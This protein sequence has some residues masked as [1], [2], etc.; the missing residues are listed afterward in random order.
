M[1]YTVLGSAGQIGKH[2][3]HFLQ[4][5]GHEVVEFDIL[6]A[7]YQ[8]LRIDYAVDS[9]IE[10]SDFTFFLAFDVGGSQYL[11]KYQNTFEFVDNNV[12]ILTNTFRALQATGKP[13]LFASTQMSNMNFSSYGTLKAVGE[14]YCRSLNSPIIKFW[15][16]YGV[17]T[18]PQKTHVITDFVKMALSGKPITM[19]TD[20]SEE[21]Q[22]L[23][24]SDCCEALY[25]LSLDYNRLSRL[26]EYHITSFEW[27]SVKHVASIISELCGGATIIPSIEH[28]TVQ[29]DQRNE[30][31]TFIKS[32]G[33]WE[34][35]MNLKNGI[36]RIVEYEKLH[37]SH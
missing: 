14:H 12:R 35:K 19:R 36:S 8:D 3:T 29:R 7:P 2:L 28:D 17:E 21:R 25:K 31:N 22:F 5:K 23:Y 1:K 30:P 9:Y 6:N 37:A 10:E 4:E 33:V 24:A 26:S 20:G 27:V 13:F 34:P 18:D 32:N 11:K 15:N 16:V